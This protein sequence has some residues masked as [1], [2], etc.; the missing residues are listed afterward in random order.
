MQLIIVAVNCHI[1]ALLASAPFTPGVPP[2]GEASWAMGEQWKRTGE[3]GEEKGAGRGV[4]R[5]GAA[6]SV[7]GEKGRWQI[8]HT[9]RSL[10]PARC[11]VLHP[12]PR[13]RASHGDRAFGGRGTAQ[14]T[15]WKMCAGTSKLVI[16]WG[17]VLCPAPELS[18]RTAHMRACSIGS[19]QTLFL[20][21][22]VHKVRSTTLAKSDCSNLYSQNLVPFVI[23]F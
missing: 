16:S 2:S 19:V 6:A 21:R 4:S 11:A 20:P 12:T 15:K 3:E 23:F 18:P 1:G 17:L 5:A 7:C 22:R 10:S 9:H 8:A 13:P 14:Q